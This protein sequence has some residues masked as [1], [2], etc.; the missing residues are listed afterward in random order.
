MLQQR[1]TQ[2]KARMSGSLRNSPSTSWS[3]AAEVVFEMV[4]VGLIPP[5]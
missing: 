2:A 1:E 4:V 5:A 3:I